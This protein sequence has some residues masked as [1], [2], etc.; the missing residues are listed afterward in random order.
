MAPLNFVHKT[1]CRDR[2]VIAVSLAATSKVLKTVR[3]RSLFQYRHPHEYWYTRRCRR[4][5]YFMITVQVACAETPSGI[6]GQPTGR[7]SA[8]PSR[9]LHLP[10]RAAGLSRFF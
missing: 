9:R 7:T 8:G 2:Y 1:R 10:R 6:T 3:V 5:Y 4:Q